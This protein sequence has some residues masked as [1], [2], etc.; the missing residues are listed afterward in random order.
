MHK[1]QWLMQ[2]ILACA[3][4]VRLLAAGRRNGWI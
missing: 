1:A 3:A 2:V 4:L